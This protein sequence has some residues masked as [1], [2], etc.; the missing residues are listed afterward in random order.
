[1]FP[2]VRPRRLRASEASRRLVRETHL[3]PADFVMPLF[4]RPGKNE[5][6]PVRSMPG[7]AQ[8][9]VDIAVKE[10]RE[11]R[12]LGVPAVILFGVPAVKDATGTDAANPDGIVQRAVRAIKDA[13][14][15]LVVV[16]DLCLCEYTDHGH[17]GVVTGTG[18]AAAIDND[19]TLD[20]LGRIAQVQAAAGA[21]WVAP[22]GM[23]DG[24][25]GAIRRALDEGGHAGTALLAYAAKYA[26]AFYGPFRDAAQSTPAFGDRRSHQM[27][28]ANAREALREVALDVKE[29]ADMVM[30]K[31]A[32]AYLDIVRRVR[33]RFDVPVAAYNVSGEY[34]LVK[35]A[36]QKGWIDGDRV[37]EEVLLSIKRAGA[38]VILTYH[39]L[40][41]ARRL[42]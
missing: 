29:G 15:E 4:V 41:M 12:R 13:C 28:A 11:S 36:A 16:T 23:M 42:N 32:L 2:R 19:A 3:T 8:I 30:V 39:A 27:D 9:S 20:L 7:V 6:R 26:S 34:A 33:D 40:E 18:R 14:P 25:V 10:A 35:A 22:S 17:C 21:D 38:D 31:P 24:A 1:M 37:M 5:R